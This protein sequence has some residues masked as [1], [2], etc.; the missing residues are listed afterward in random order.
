MSEARKLLYELCGKWDDIARTGPSDPNQ[1]RRYLDE[2]LFQADLRFGDYLQFRETHGEFP[3]RFFQ[4]LS[5]TDPTN[6]KKALFKL[7]TYLVFIDRSQSLSLC[8]DA[9]RRIIIPWLVQ[10]S[11]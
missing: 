7:L 2:I 10:N 4:W 6:H 1:Y 8:R 5:N 11:N 9:Y 3:V